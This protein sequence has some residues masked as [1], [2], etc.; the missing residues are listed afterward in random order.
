M[1]SSM[2]GTAVRMTPKKPSLNPPASAKPRAGKR[3]ASTS[4]PMPEAVSVSPAAT[5]PDGALFEGEVGAQYLLPLLAGGEAR[6]LPG[7]VVTQV[8][9][10]RGGFGH[11]MDDVIVT[12]VDSTG[13]PATLE[14]QAKRTVTFS[15]GDQVFRDVVSQAVRCAAK[16]EFAS[17]RYQVAVAV[18]RTTT[19]IEFYCQEVLVWARRLGSAAAFFAH[20]ARPGFAHQEMRDFVTS[21]RANMRL[22]GGTYDDAAVW[23]LLARFQILPFD[24]GQP[25]STWQLLA[26]DRCAGLLAPDSAA[27]AAALW[28]TLV[29][30]A[31]RFDAGAGELTRPSLQNL[32]TGEAGYRLAGDRRLRAA[33]RILAEMSA[34]AL[35]EIATEVRGVRLD[36]GARVDS[37]ISALQQGRFLDIRGAGGV[38]KSGVLKDL[39]E[40]VSVESCSVVLAPNRVRGGGW[41]ELRLLLGCDATAV[42]FLTDL[43]GDGGSTIFID[44]VDRF[45][46]PAQRATVVDLIRAAAE[47]PTCKVV[48]TARLDFDDEARSWLPAASIAKLGIAP[49]LIVEELDETEVAQL[50]GADP[51]LAALLRVSQGAHL[52][53]NLYRLSRLSRGSDGTAIERLPASEA[54]MAHQWWTTG[55]GGPAGRRERRRLLRALAT[56][57]LQASSPMDATSQSAEPIEAL[58]GSDS[59]HEGSSIDRITFAHDVLLDWAVGCLIVDEPACLESLPLQSPA[60]AALVRGLEIAARLHAELSV[61]GASWLALLQRVDGAQSHG[62]WRRAVLLALPRSELASD[63]FDRCAREL[64]SGEAELFADIVRAAIALDSQPAAPLWQAVGAD[65]S[66]LSS[67]FVAPRGATWLNIIG[68]S[69]RRGAD[70]PK[71]T[72][73]HLVDLYARW[74]QSLGGVDPVSPLLVRLLYSWLVEVE[75]AVHP[76]TWKERR[77]PFG[78]SISLARETDL[79]DALRTAFL[80]SC[81][82]CPA[83][84]EA[85][86][87]RVAGHHMRHVLFRPMLKF[88]GSAAQAAPAALADLFLGALTEEDPDKGR[89][90]D[91]SLYRQWDLDFMPPSPVQGPYL[92]LLRASPDDGLRL[93]RGVVAHAV[94]K[95]ARGM[96]PGA[97]AI[98]IPLPDGARS[99]PWI[100]S[101]LWSRGDESYIVGS[102]LMALEAWSHERIES[103]DSVDH[104]LEDLLGPPG[105]CAAYLLVAIDTLLSH[106]PTSRPALWPFASSAEMLAL[107]RQRWSQDYM[108]QG[109][110]PFAQTSD[111]AA[112]AA[113]SRGLRERPSRGGP[114]DGVL[115]DYGWNG[116]SATRDAMKRALEADASR[117][118]PPDP[119]SAGFANA[120]FAA[121]SALN[122]LDP[123]NYAQVGVD[124]DGKPAVQY[125]A[126][127][128][129]TSLLGAKQRQASESS[130]D[131]ATRGQLAQ[132]IEA[133]ET[134]SAELLEKALT[135]DSSCDSGSSPNRPS[136]DREWMERTRL[137]VAALIL[138]DGSPEMQKANRS[139]A[140]DR[141]LAVLGRKPD[142]PGFAQKLPFNNAGIAGVGLLALVRHSTD[143]EELRRLLLLTTRR[144]AG[145]VSILRLDWVAKR[146][147]RPELARSM[148]RLGMVSAI[149]AVAG[150]DERGM[151]L[152]LGAE[153]YSTRRRRLD[154][155]RKHAEEARLSVAVED[156]LEWIEGR[157]M[158]P[159]WPQFPD[160]RA[161]KTRATIRLDRTPPPV[162]PHAKTVRRFGVDE[163]AASEWLTLA[164]D[165]WCVEQGALVRDLL[166]HYWNWTAS[167]NGVGCSDDEEPGERTTDWNRAYFAAALF[168]AVRGG[169]SDVDA[170]LLDPVA[171]LPDDPFLVVTESLLLSLDRMWLES[172]AVSE[173]IALRVRSHLLQRLK[174]TVAWGRLVSQA[175]DSTEVHLVGALASTYFSQRVL[176]GSPRC[177]LNPI[178]LGRISNFLPTLAQL[179]VDAGGST[180]AALSFLSVL[181][182]DPH[183]SQLAVVVRAVEAWGKSRGSDAGFWVNFG[184]GRRACV[185]VEKALLDKP[186]DRALLE[187]EDLSTLIDNLVRHGIPLAKQLED[188]IT[189]QRVSAAP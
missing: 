105:S 183:P 151:G 166:R 123:S 78:L 170:L 30:T 8:A 75:E 15:A 70:L 139:W 158:E 142:R 79:E 39:A 22:A 188:R 101:Y 110:G 31:L 145:I 112:G 49:P 32:L 131:L 73:P 121:T 141:L 71:A 124:S 133:R 13:Q 162:R 47:V 64:T 118:G 109:R 129:E 55:D 119:L 160:P 177:Y 69:L 4:R 140:R 65:V 115:D 20:L 59:V 150:D 155:Q 187:A 3:A 7:V 2:S 128:S 26:R 108:M 116:P 163:S 67:D 136:D 50:E 152:D 92:E 168:V 11:P 98:S 95:R 114:L 159:S 144:D 157:A 178:G 48:T 135:W 24:F 88:R 137:I 154:E 181:E 161:P 1:D 81:R 80:M 51:P 56:H 46:D 82:L 180:F 9:F 102:A 126:P 149:Y 21:F 44:S 176:G 29:H 16:P 66:K 68:W 130:A 58:I 37:A 89:T 189:Q 94:T 18:A 36:R 12:G 107:D 28:D 103:G 38:G 99:F 84:T 60:P 138:R 23:R 122:R 186:A 63:L 27:L 147:V 117:L 10:Q 33:R 164:C 42:E 34:G 156:E 61:D 171:K 182:V 76:R 14:I 120:R 134:C 96:V 72:I 25:G 184:V 54:Q 132:A 148:V 185:W 83:E 77:N 40:R 175:S 167:A 91:T 62:S 52:V 57:F 90:R 113:A 106:W 87:R 6:G 45:V 41:S 165:L 169:A 97:N 143:S 104:V 43:A 35:A 17:S 179:T 74:T 53:R 125:V 173:P 93:V 153:D 172:G 100:Q 111:D 174:A 85:Y 5:G 146:Y 86:L 19:K 127:E